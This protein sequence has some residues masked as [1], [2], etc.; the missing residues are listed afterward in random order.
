VT[1]TRR[2]ALRFN[3][4]RFREELF[5]FVDEVLRGGDATQRAA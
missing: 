3:A 4:E 1:A 2:Q 5:A